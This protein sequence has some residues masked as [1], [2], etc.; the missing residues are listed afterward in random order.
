MLLQQQ[1]YRQRRENFDVNR[2]RFVQIIAVSERI[3]KMRKNGNTP[4]VTLRE[5]TLRSSRSSRVS[6]KNVTLSMRDLS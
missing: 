3:F 5:P 6:A 2:G 1:Q 4:D